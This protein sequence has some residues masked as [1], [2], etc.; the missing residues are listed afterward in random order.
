MTN[1]NHNTPSIEQRIDILADTILKF[2]SIITDVENT[3]ANSKRELGS[4]ALQLNEL[5]LLKDIKDG[6]LVV[7]KKDT[8]ERV[9]IQFI[10]Q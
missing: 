9:N 5:R 8:L 10:E 6:K 4:L 1:N 3:L 7:L 2:N